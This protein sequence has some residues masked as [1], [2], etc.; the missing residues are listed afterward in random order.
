MVGRGC[1]RI[2]LTGCGQRSTRRVGRNGAKGRVWQATWRSEE[3]PGLQSPAAKPGRQ[4]LAAFAGCWLAVAVGGDVGV[5]WRVGVCAR[6]SR[7]LRQVAACAVPARRSAAAHPIPRARARHSQPHQRGEECACSSA[8]PAPAKMVGKERAPA[9]FLLQVSG[10]AVLGRL[11]LCGVIQ[12]HESGLRGVG[13]STRPA[14]RTAAAA[15]AR[16]HQPHLAPH[17]H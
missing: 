1:C 6:R 12:G 10:W 15:A 3:D 16:R 17:Q 14:S 4:P 13:A 7:R 11:G 9:K 2:W 5:G 8:R